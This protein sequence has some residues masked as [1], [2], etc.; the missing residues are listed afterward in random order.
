MVLFQ[1]ADVGIGICGQEGLEAASMSDYSIGQFRFLERLLFIHGAWSFQ[2]NTKVF[3]I[4]LLFSNDFYF[5][6]YKI[7]CTCNCVFLLGNTGF[8]LQKCLLLFG[9][10]VDCAFFCIFRSRIF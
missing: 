10:T 1:R 4:Y 7:D 2:R 5:H 6:V 9:W 8:F 3:F